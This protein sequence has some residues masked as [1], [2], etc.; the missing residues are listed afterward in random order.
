MSSPEKITDVVQKSCEEIKESLVAK[1]AEA[2]DAAEVIK[3]VVETFFE[4]LRR[5]GYSLY[6]DEYL[7]KKLQKI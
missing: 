5:S 7:K 6:L 4:R 2:V 1:E 3:S